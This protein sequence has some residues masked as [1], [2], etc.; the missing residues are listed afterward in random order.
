MKTLTL[1]SLL[2]IPCLAL[3]ASAPT[4]AVSE[5]PD[6]YAVW[7]VVLNY[8]YPAAASR[9][10]V[11]ENEI[12]AVPESP[13]QNSAHP[14]DSYS[15]IEIIIDESRQP[16][17]LERKFTLELPYV[18]VP[19]DEQPEPTRMSLDS[20]KVKIDNFAKLQSEW[21]QFYKKYPGAYGIVGFSHVAFLNHGTQAAVIVTSRERISTSAGK[22]YL[23]AKKNG[24]WEVAMVTPL[25]RDI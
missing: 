24:S 20:G 23:L 8:G 18:L 19:R 21:D 4:T 9:Q 16:F 25:I 10:L 17:T 5:Q 12:A 15:E 22:L 2:A 6:E 7:S 13:S 3:A 14:Y 11:I 1:T